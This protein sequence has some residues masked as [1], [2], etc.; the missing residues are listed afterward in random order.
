M[1]HLQAIRKFADAAANTHVIIVKDDAWS[2]NVWEKKPRL[3]IPRDLFENDDDDVA[4]RADFI[5]R[6]PLAAAYSDIALTILHELG[7][8]FTKEVFIAADYNDYKDITGA[9]YFKIPHEM[10][11]TNWAIA[12]L[13]DPAHLPIIDTFEKDFI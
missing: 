11:A 5:S 4:F 6:C 9:A 2:M 12:W 7:H 10:A 13:N 1:T 3:H 8:F